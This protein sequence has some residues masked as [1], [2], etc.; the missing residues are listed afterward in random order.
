MREHNLVQMYITN[1]CNSHCKTCSIWKNK[2]KEY[3]SLYNIEYIVREALEIDPMTDFVIGG[4]EAILH[5]QIINILKIL[6]KYNV[7]YTLLSNCMSIN[8]LKILVSIYNVKNVTVSFDGIY[9][10]E[11]RGV[12]GNKEKIIHFIKWCKEKDINLKLSYTYSSFNEDMF[13][14][15][16]D[17]IKNE[18]GLDKVYFCLAQNM[19]L[20]KSESDKII[21]K[22]FSKILKRK[23]MLF[24]KDIKYIESM[25]SGN[26]NKCDSQSSVF[27]I[28]S[29][30]NMVRCQSYMSKDVLCNIKN[31]TPRRLEHIFGASK[32]IDCKYDKEC[33]LLCQRRYD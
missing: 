19:E 1:Q 15:D 33:N 26:K 10:N 32:C 28:Y 17:Y 24:D 2:E 11:T 30:G 23:E 12:V 6:N 14:E 18:L 25:L 21:A 16:M 5:P 22:D 9:H 13:L 7:N 8:T 27:T 4:G 29:N 3:L 20:L 31:V